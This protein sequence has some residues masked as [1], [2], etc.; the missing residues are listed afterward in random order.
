MCENDM[1]YCPENIWRKQDAKRKAEQEIYPRLDFNNITALLRDIAKKTKKE[2]K[3]M[4][5]IVVPDLRNKNLIIGPVFRIPIECQGCEKKFNEL[6][7][8]DGGL[9]DNCMMLKIK[10]G[11]LTLEESKKQVCH[12]RHKELEQLFI[13]EL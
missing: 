12:C 11:E 8:L 10:N 5:N 1:Y 3:G 4:K 2:D 7:P 6:W 9:C 13:V